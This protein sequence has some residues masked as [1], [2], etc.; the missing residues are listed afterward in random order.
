MYLSRFVRRPSP[1]CPEAPRVSSTCSMGEHRVLT[2]AETCPNTTPILSTLQARWLLVGH[3]RRSLQFLAALAL[4]VF[5]I[6]H[7]QQYFA[8]PHA[9]SAHIQ[10]WSIR[11][12]DFVARAVER[13]TKLISVTVWRSGEHQSAEVLEKL[14]RDPNLV[15]FLSDVEN[16]TNLKFY[17]PKYSAGTNPVL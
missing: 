15:A 7:S 11:K 5:Y 9:E 2:Y 6:A 3:V 12:D 13:G 16:D 8:S 1:Q 4:I 10:R 17:R 14:S